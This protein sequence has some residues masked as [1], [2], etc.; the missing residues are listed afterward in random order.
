MYRQALHCG[1]MSDTVAEWGGPLV[2]SR[3]GPIARISGK[4]F[5]QASLIE[6]AGAAEQRE[7]RGSIETC[8]RYVEAVSRID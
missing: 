3:R 4:D 8:A 6:T 2:N 7:A 5:I 1:V